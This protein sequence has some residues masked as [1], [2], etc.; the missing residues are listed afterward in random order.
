MFHIILQIWR[1]C[2]DFD[3]KTRRV[4]L[5]AAWIQLEKIP[6]VSAFLGLQGLDGF[7]FSLQ[8][9]DAA[10]AFLDFVDLLSHNLVS[11]LRAPK[12]GILMFRINF[13]LA[14][15]LVMIFSGCQST[16]RKLAKKLEDSVFRLHLEARP[17]GSH[18]IG[19]VEIYRQNPQTISVEKNAFLDERYITGAEIIEDGLGG[20]VIRVE[21]DRHGRWTLENITTT[22]KRR[23]IAIMAEW[24]EVRWIAAPFIARPIQDGVITF[25]PDANREEADRI[26]EGLNKGAKRRKKNSLFQ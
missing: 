5:R 22:F 24:G 6:V 7:L 9:L 13:Y 12:M 1:S 19:E 26:V 2:P 10:T 3:K 17:D 15:A 20:F 8:A 25:T 16:S 23:R 11:V 21:F 18:R 4:C 14:V